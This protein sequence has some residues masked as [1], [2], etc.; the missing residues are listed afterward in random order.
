MILFSGDVGTGKTTLAESFG[1]RIARDERIKVT[2]L[3]LSLMTRG[4]GA[5]GEMTHLMSQAFAEVET[6]ASRGATGKKTASAV[7]LIIDEADALAESRD[8]KEMHHEDRAGVNALI[9][10]IDRLSRKRLP[11]LIVLCT[12]REEAIDPAVLR[13]AAAHYR[14]ERP[15]DEQRAVLIRTALGEIFSEAELEKLVELTGPQD[16]RSYGYTYSDITGR[17]IPRLLL[18]AFPDSGITF[19][20]AAAVVEKTPPTRPFGKAEQRPHTS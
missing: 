1:D 19:V 15:N 17:L 10:G 11:V 2:V 18:E 9:R 20:L 8:V 3:R 16:G 4:R 5:V 6:L 14:F 7:I 12:N 13:R